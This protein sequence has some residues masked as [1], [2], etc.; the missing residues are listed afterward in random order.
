MKTQPVHCPVCKKCCPGHIPGI[1]EEGKTEI[2][3]KN[4]RECNPKTSFYSDKD[5]ITDPFSKGVQPEPGKRDE[6]ICR[7]S[8]DNQSFHPGSDNKDRKQ[9][10]KKD[11]AED[12]NSRE[13]TGKD[14]VEIKFLS[15]RALF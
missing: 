1:F 4:K 7:K 15:F 3:G 9:E 13:G 8:P 14:A 11:Q 2:K 10:G 5:G 12:R 6:N